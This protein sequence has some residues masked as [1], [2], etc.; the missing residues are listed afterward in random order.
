MLSRVLTS[1]WR[2]HVTVTGMRGPVS[3]HIN[4]TLSPTVTLLLRLFKDTLTSV[5]VEL[6]IISNGENARRS[7][8]HRSDDV[9]NSI[10]K[11]ETVAPMLGFHHLKLE[12]YVLQKK[13]TS[14]L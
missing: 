10:S 12:Q 5:S 2:L 7:G 3:R 13:D 1:R 11:K 14:H 9:S 8:G 4:S 6:E